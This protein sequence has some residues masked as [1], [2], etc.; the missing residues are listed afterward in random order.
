MLLYFERILKGQI[1]LP[2]EKMEA[3]NGWK[4]RASETADQL[5]PEWRLYGIHKGE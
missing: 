2:E 4:F 3:D 5:T 1:C